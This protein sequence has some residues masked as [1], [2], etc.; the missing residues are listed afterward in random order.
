MIAIPLY[1]AEKQLRKTFESCVRQSRPA[2]IILID[3]QSEDGTVALAQELIRGHK[4]FELRINETNLGRTGNWNR[5]IKIFEESKCDILKFLFSGDELLQ[6]CVASFETVY[7]QNE[8]IATVLWPLIYKE[9]CGTETVGLFSQGSTIFDFSTLVDKQY[10]PNGLPGGL[11][12]NAY[13]KKAISGLRFS[14]CFL[15][16][17]TFQNT[18]MTRGRVA[19]LNTPLTTFHVQARGHFPQQFR[20]EFVAEF[21]FAF[22]KGLDEAGNKLTDKQRAQLTETLVIDSFRLMLPF[23]SDTLFGKA[24]LAIIKTWFGKKMW[25]MKRL[26]NIIVSTLKGTR[27]PAEKRMPVYYK[28]KGNPPA[29]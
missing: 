23:I 28:V 13:S 9:P 2:K 15:G 7:E 29:K 25:E 19:F 21:S 14:D 12:C 22:A 3:N 1:N 8:D 5:C 18:V 16:V 17:H 27:V 24:M 26:K 4:N 6:D 10:Y 20:P 11:L